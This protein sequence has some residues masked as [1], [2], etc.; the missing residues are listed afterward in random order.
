M[1]LVS[2]VIYNR[3]LSLKRVERAGNICSVLLRCPVL[4]IVALTPPLPVIPLA[5]GE[6][7]AGLTV[8]FVSLKSWM[9]RLLNMGH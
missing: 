7:H 6:G 3:A 9:V 5:R 4:G 2:A 8:N 1:Q